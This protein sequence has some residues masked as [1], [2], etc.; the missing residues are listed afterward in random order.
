MMVDAAAGAGNERAQK[1]L[2][3]QTQQHPMMST[4]D[5]IKAAPAMLNAQLD[6]DAPEMEADWALPSW[7]RYWR[8]ARSG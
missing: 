8:S 1:R 4:N 6:M 5:M 7:V 2:Q 3:A